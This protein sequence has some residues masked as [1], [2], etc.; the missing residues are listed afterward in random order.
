MITLSFGFDANALLR[1]VLRLDHQPASLLGG[2]SKLSSGG[3][4]A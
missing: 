4:L 3:G 1:V 2:Q